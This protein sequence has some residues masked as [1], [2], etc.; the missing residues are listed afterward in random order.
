MKRIF[1]ALLVIAMTCTLL[2]GCGKKNGGDGNSLLNEA[3]KTSK[4]YVF[5]ATP[6]NIEGIKDANRL[7]LVGDRIYLTDYS[8]DGFCQVFSMSTD[9]SDIKSFKLPKADNEGYGTTAFD[10]D[11]NMYT[12]KYSYYYEEDEESSEGEDVVTYTDEASAGEDTSFLVCF[13]KDGKEVFREDLTHIM[14]G[15]D[16][17]Y[18]NSMIYDDN[19]GLIISSNRGIESYS[20]DAGFKTILDTKGNTEFT[21]VYFDVIKGYNGKTYVSY[22]GEGGLQLRT[23]DL[24][25]GKLSDNSKAFSGNSDYNF[26]YGNGY[27]LYASANEG[28]YGYDAAKDELVKLLDYMDSDIDISY[29]IGNITAV[30]DSEFIAALP[31]D[32]YNYT[33]YR[34]TKIPPNEVKDKQVILVAGNY[35]NYDYR[36]QAV[37]FNREND[38]YRIKLV[39]YSSLNSEDDWNAGQ[40]QFNLDIA[41]GNI[42]DVMLFRPEDAVGSYANKGLFVDL[43]PYIKNDPELANTEF[44]QNIMDAY[45]VNGKQLM[46]TPAFY[47]T[48]YATKKDYLEPGKEG[49][50]LKEADELIKKAG[51]QYMYAFGI[52]SKE[53]I[54]REGISFA[55]SRYIDWENKKCSF[56]SQDFVEF[57][58]FVNKFPAEISENAWED[59]A[60]DS[61][62]SG[63]ALFKLSYLDNFRSYKRLRDGDFAS[64]VSFIG[65]PNLDGA[66]TSLIYPENIIAISSRSKVSEG[67]WQFVRML[68]TKEYQ[69]KTEY[70]FPVR[71]ESFDKLAEASKEKEFYMDGNDK[72]YVDDSYYIGDQEI[73]I[74]PLNDEDIKFI[75]EYIGSLDSV[76]NSNDAIMDII[77]EEA[78]SFFNGEKTAQQV[79]D[80]IQSRVSIYVNE[81]S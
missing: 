71:Q 23:I 56:N 69:D 66:N 11:G 19:A 74:E 30:S 60:D 47:V 5:K 27:D 68:F 15:E 29:S 54:L 24:A 31:D 38:S 70:N 28:V 63:Q 46:L 4:E 79:A 58:E 26:F 78:N 13:D 76:F 53:E 17:Y 52:T 37:R 73:T 36:K 35:I 9:G 21:D 3:N 10:K 62:R 6:M 42:P 16:T 45:K 7:D 77:M 41:S 34:L 48:S 81:N 25:S 67:A 14:V 12:V 59:F 72:I 32:E 2:A 18:V 44:L 43:D 40:T 49:M 33:I 57:L 51:A 22:Y 80:I 20:K 55:G 39:D 75:K 1:A 61:Y 8:S 64:D 65:F 50:T